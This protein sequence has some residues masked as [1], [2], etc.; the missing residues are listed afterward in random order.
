MSSKPAGGGLRLRLLRIGG[1]FKEKGCEDAKMRGCKNVRM[2]VVI[3]EVKN[4]ERG[5]SI[6]K[7]RVIFVPDVTAFD[8][9][10]AN[11]VTSR[12]VNFIFTHHN[13]HNGAKP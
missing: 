9:E 11:S 8:F 13:H 7:L 6:G 5:L 3:R 2:S 10:P 4:R 12:L 1:I